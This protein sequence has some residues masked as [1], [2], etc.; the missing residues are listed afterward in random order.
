MSY[1][2]ASKPNVLTKPLSVKEMEI[3]VWQQV[4]LFWLAQGSPVKYSKEKADGA[5]E[6]YRAHLA[7]QAKSEGGV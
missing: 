6:G 5:V 3:T 1:E 2:M 7:E 4:Y